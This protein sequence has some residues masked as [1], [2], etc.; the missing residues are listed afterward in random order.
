[1][2]SGGA[3]VGVRRPWGLLKIATLLAKMD[4][5]GFKKQVAGRDCH[6]IENFASRH[7]LNNRWNWTFTD[8]RSRSI[9]SAG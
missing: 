8:E 6:R 3:A 9:K 4:P 5:A 1:M 7:E 2:L